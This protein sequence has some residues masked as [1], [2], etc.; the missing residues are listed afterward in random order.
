V[1]RSG[2]GAALLALLEHLGHSLGGE[3]R[4]NAGEMRGSRVGGADSV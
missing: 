1:L 3:R 4:R 2:D